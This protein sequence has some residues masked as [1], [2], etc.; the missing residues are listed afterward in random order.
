MSDKDKRKKIQNLLMFSG[1]VSGVS[2]YTADED[3]VV[4]E[5]SMIEVPSHDFFE[6]GETDD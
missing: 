6:D 3:L 5:E 2:N 4:D 1:L